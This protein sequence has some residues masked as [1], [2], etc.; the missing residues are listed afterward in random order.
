MRWASMP[1][2]C[3]G[4]LAKAVAYGVPVLAGDL[5]AATPNVPLASFSTENEVQGHC[6]GGLVVWLDPASKT[7]YFRGQQR[8]GAN[9]KGVYVCRD[10]AK[11]AGM[12]ETRSSQ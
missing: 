2:H 12:K 11:S 3:V 1:P 10:E 5:L 9:Q 7:Y 4:R 6:P 8:Y